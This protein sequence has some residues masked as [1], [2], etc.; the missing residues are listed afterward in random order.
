MHHPSKRYHQQRKCFFVNVTKN[1][2]IV[3]HPEIDTLNSSFDSLP[4]DK[5]YPGPN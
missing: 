2:E 1:D 4:N 5:I 3:T